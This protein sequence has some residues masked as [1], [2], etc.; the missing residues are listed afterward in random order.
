MYVPPDAEILEA[1]RFGCAR[2]AEHANALQCPNICV[3]Q[4]IR[5]ATLELRNVEVIR[6]TS[7]QRSSAMSAILAG[8]AAPFRCTADAGNMQLRN[9]NLN[10]SCP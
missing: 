10:V 1:V 3:V 9:F 7:K 5:S 4:I 2:G 6:T 8:P